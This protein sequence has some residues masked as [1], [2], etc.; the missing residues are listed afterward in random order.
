MSVLGCDKPVIYSDK[1]IQN[2]VTTVYFLHLK[3]EADPRGFNLHL[4]LSGK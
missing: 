4:I 3:A 1:K 2:K